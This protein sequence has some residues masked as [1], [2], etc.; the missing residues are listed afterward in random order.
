MTEGGFNSP[1][2]YHCWCCHSLSSFKIWST[3]FLCSN[4]LVFDWQNH[5]GRFG[6]ECESPIHNNTL[7]SCWVCFFNVH[8]YAFQGLSAPKSHYCFSFGCSSCM[9][10][11]DNELRMTPRVC[12]ILVQ[13]PN[14]RPF[15]FW[16]IF[17]TGRVLEIAISQLT[18]T[19]TQANTL[20]IT[21]SGNT[22]NI[23]DMS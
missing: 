21:T 5:F 9:M 2:I 3:N 10:K 1:T 6:I 15:T 22:T 13:S 11:H 14:G 17:P 8:V 16:A 20:A 23:T 19:P 4:H 12:M 7:E 18:N